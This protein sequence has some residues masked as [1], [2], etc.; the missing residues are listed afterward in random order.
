[1]ITKKYLMGTSRL[2]KGEDINKLWPKYRR[3][4]KP[5]EFIKLAQ[6]HNFSNEYIQYVIYDKDHAVWARADK[7]VEVEDWDTL[8]DNLI[9][10]YEG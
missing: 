3:R 8:V 2:G 6:Q 1:M 9:R 10:E 7:G 4:L 5:L